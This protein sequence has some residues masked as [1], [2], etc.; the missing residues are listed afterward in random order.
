MEYSLFSRDA[1]EQGQIDAC[2]ELG[3]AMMTYAVLGRGMLS[4]QVPKV[5]ELAAD[6]SAR[7]R[8]SGACGAGFGF[9][10]TTTSA[11]VSFGLPN[12]TI[13][14]LVSFNLT[15]SLVFIPSRARSAVSRRQIQIDS[16][17][18]RGRW[19]AVSG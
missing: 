6:D 10:L 17:Q 15:A 18:L 19:H 13:R 5:E 16:S 4:D 9:N 8:D 12:L 2:G 14:A 1:E 7:C 11:V 3:M